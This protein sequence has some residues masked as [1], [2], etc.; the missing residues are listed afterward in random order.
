MK[1]LLS[2]MLAVALMA[3]VFTG[4][5]STDT[6]SNSSNTA[7]NTPSNTP[8][9]T[10][11][12][13]STD[14]DPNAPVFLIGGSGPLTGDYA[15][16]GVSVKQGAEIAVAEINASGGVNGMALQFKM[17]DDQAD[18]EMAK[19]AYATLID[20][21]MK[22]SL[23]AV[24]SGACLSA[25]DEALID[26]ILMI[27]PSGSQKECVDNYNAFRICFND[28]DQGK[29]AASFIADNSVASSVAIIYD[30]SNDYSVG[31]TNTFVAQAEEA[32]LNIVAQ[33]AFTDQS[34]TDFSVQLQSIKDSGAEL[35]FLPIYA[36]EAAYILTQAEK[37]ELDVIFFGCD[38]LDGI[39][40]K[41]G[42]DN[43]HL[44]EGLMLLTPFAA[45]ST[46]PAVASFVSTYQAQFNTT[47]DQFAADGYDAIYAV[48]LAIEEAGITDVEDAELNDKLIAAMTE[49]KL[50]GT[51]GTMTWGE[52]G[53]PVKSAMAIVITDGVYVA[54]E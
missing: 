32:G 18:A 37:I 48:A 43:V 1:K 39:L 5:G 6:T 45:D 38:G 54:F 44:T 9:N 52:D 36:Q 10:Q 25:A 3:T 11:T 19:N 4:C 40:Q 14:I 29:Y 7:N 8:S 15:T 33:E 28:P 22:V 27:T 23:G 41:I 24:T 16:Y 42:D 20:S 34:N 12:Q 30:R 53:E 47:P 51:T 35:V 46:E 17:E 21:G 49:I 13:T 50:Y 31:I 26:G 2:S